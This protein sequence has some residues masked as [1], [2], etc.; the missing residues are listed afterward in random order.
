MYMTYMALESFAAVSLT[1]L[2]C[3][4]RL[5]GFGPDPPRTG[6]SNAPYQPYNRFWKNSL[7]IGPLDG[8]ALALVHCRKAV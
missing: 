2:P 7:V 4:E 5:Q 3:C 6:K 1:L 8:H